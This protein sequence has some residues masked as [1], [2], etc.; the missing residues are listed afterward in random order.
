MT[1]LDFLTDQILTR[2]EQ[3]A[4]HSE[5]TAGLTRRFLTP[6][7]HQVHSDLSRWMVEAGLQVRV[8]AIGNMIGRRAGAAD[9]VFLVGS[10]VDTVP[11]AGK[12][13]GILGVL[14]GVAAAEA[15]MGKKLSQHLDIIAF[16][17]EE[18]VRFRTPFLGSLAICGELP[19]EFLTLRDAGEKT[20]A[21]AIVDFGLDPAAVPAAAYPAGVLT[22]Y[23]EAHIEQGPV[24]EAG[25]Y[26]LATVSA[27][28]GQ[29]R[30][31]ITFTGKAGHAGTCPMELRR[32]ALCGAA[33]FILCLEPFAANSPGLR[34]TVGQISV[35]PGAGNVIPGEA[36][37]SLDVRHETDFY[38]ESALKFAVNMAKQTALRRQLSCDIEVISDQQAVPCDT[39]LTAQLS[40]TLRASG[41]SALYGMVSGAG[42]DAA[43]LSRHCPATMLFLRSPGGVSHHSDEAVLRDDV[44]AALDVM[45]RFLRD[46][47]AEA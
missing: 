1:D 45:I 20:L 39:Q 12:F 21:E 24:L 32:D 16:S 47:L 13:D 43:I 18:G 26:R 35:S 27:I 38:R 4:R 42:H 41:Y 2:C 6:P 3:L 33:H 8:D 31:R 5:T 34:A 46:L 9:K 15:L 11:N 37:L 10:H 19:S 22:G 40:Q 44:R 28:A 25:G 17:E 29:S 7:M 36:C 23:L 14:L 30:R